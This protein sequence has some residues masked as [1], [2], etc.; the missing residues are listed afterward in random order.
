MKFCLTA[1][2]SLFFLA[3]IS[4]ASTNL[5][6]VEDFMAEPDLLDIDISPSGR[7]MAEVRKV[8]KLRVAVVRDLSSP[9]LKIIG[10]IGD[11]VIRPYAVTWAKDER[12]VVHLLV[13]YNTQK[14]IRE[15]DEEDF[16]LDEHFM[17]SRSIAMDPDGK[18]TVALMADT[19]SLRARVNLSNIRHTMPE[20]PKHILMSSFHNERLAL[21][22]VNVFDGTS[23]KLIVG[24]RN[25]TYFICETDGTPRYRIDYLP[26]RKKMRILELTDGGKWL[27]VD[28]I[29]TDEDTDDMDDSSILVGLTIQG[30]LTYRKK[31]P[32][33]GYYELVEQNRTDKTLT[34][35]ASSPNND[36]AGLIYQGRNDQVI[37]YRVEEDVL[38]NKYFDAA[39]QR[40]YDS[41]RKRLY[42]YGFHYMSSDKKGEHI[43]IKS[44]GLDLPAGYYLYNAKQDELQFYD[45]GYKSLPSEKMGAPGIAT[46]NSR[47]GLP[48]RTYLLFPAG[49]QQGKKYPLVVMPHGGPHS[50]DYALYDDF[51][52]FV[53]SQGYFV[54]QPNFRGSTGYGKKFEEAGYKQWG[55]TMQ[56]DL[57]DAAQFLIKKGYIQTDKICLVGASYGGYAALMGLVK[58]GDFY[59]CAISINGV[60]HLA[61]QVK[62]DEK[63]FRKRQEIIDFAH[64]SIG[65]PETDADLLAANSPLLHIDKINDPVMI[66]A[67]TDDNV[68]PYKQSKSLV[69][70]LQK[71]KKPVEWV[72]LKDTGHHA[73]YF[74]E[75][76]ETVY[77]KTRDFLAKHLR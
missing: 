57:Q 29:N 35:L 76:R 48:I 12:L 15:S 51:A 9:N 36:I 44:Y 52:S 50:R 47:D 39:T 5:L 42:G 43:A 6:T 23:E 21:F 62:F 72:S 2:L 16:D 58:H 26:I 60:T 22:K 4:L 24:G 61:D 55:G 56:D 18:N 53:A 54:V 64:K 11:S 75:D 40:T 27:N 46:F 17:F 73:L 63:R 20:D 41:I 45:V 13:P 19:R 49:Y 71:A 8:G 3:N 74:D 69:K 34:V 59:R 70:A 31:N 37:G 30:A 1:F 33:T 67:G 10:K 7:Y 32:T 66:V 28:E 38:V 68:V 65:H 14:V 77:T 25:T